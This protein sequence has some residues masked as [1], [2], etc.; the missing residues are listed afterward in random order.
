LTLI[1]YVTKHLFSETSGK[2]CVDYFTDRR[3]KI[4]RAHGNLF[5][6]EDLELEKF[7][8]KPRV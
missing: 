5:W 1:Y 6:I 8:E 4:K 7:E 3:G 2:Q